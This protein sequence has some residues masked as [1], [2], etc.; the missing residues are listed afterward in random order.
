[1]DM[2]PAPS[3]LVNRFAYG[4]QDFER[5][6]TVVQDRVFSIGHQRTNR[7]RSSVE[8]I[9]SVLIAYLPETTWIRPGRHSFEHHGGGTR[10]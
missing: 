9:D 2:I 10:D 8:L 5:I 7:S 3:L 6:E 1:M 4:A